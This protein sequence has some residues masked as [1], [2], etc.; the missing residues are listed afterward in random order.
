M[1]EFDKTPPNPAESF[2]WGSIYNSSEGKTGVDFRQ[3]VYWLLAPG[4]QQP[5]YDALAAEA[6]YYAGVPE[7]G[8]IVDGG[9][10]HPGGFLKLMKEIGHTGELIGFEPYPEQFDG[11]PYWKPAEPGSNSRVQTSSDRDKFFLRVYGSG[12]QMPGI[13]LY[14]ATADSIPLPDHTA[15][16]ATTIFSGYHAFKNR[17]GLIEVKRILKTPADFRELPE[18]RQRSGIHID[19]G[20]G[21]ENKETS[22]K[23]EGKIAEILSR[24]TGVRILPPPKLQEGFTTE[25]AVDELP[26][27]YRR[28]YLMT[29]RQEMIYN[30]GRAIVLN[31]HMTYRDSYTVEG[32]DLPS[33]FR[34]ETRRDKQVVTRNLFKLAS[35]LVVGSKIDQANL[36]E[37]QVTDKTRRH[38]I[39][40]SD[41]E[42]DLP[43]IK[44]GYEDGYEEITNKAA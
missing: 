36:E 5:D 10:S 12:K 43:M 19:I 2:D 41:E 42:V 11:L 32:G 7:D 23:D 40:A 21:N 27:L 3:A 30:Y 26:K 37:K 16:A 44:D 20:S 38:V 14:Q 18:S 24:M 17:A 1:S 22:I 25:D 6:L 31:A 34:D 28:V 9:C 4:I 29:I 39:V 13:D 33:L 8:V 35:E 15:N